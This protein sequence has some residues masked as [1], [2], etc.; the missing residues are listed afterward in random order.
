MFYL[1]AMDDMECKAEFRFR[2]NEIPRLA[3]APDI[4][5]KFF[6]A[7]EAQQLLE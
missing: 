6:F 3:E 7:T 4:P 2:K 5:E 1:Y